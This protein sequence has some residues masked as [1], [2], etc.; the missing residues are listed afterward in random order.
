MKNA[1]SAPAR[2]ALPFNDGERVVTVNGFKAFHLDAEP[3][4]MD[5]PV[6]FFR[7][8]ADYVLHKA[9]VVV[10]LLRHKLFNT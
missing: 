10:G 1:P 6:Q 8:A 4:Y 2:P 7:H 5:M 3:A 9:G